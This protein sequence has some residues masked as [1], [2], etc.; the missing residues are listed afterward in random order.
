MSALAAL[1]IVLAMLALSGAFRR[2]LL[3]TRDQQRAEL[4]DLGL[5]L[6]PDGEWTGT[7]DGTLLRHGLPRGASPPQAH[8][9]Q[10]SVLTGG[11]ILYS[12]RVLGTEAP[13]STG[14]P[15]FDA[16]YLSRGTPAERSLLTSAVRRALLGLSQARLSDGELECEASPTPDSLRAVLRVVRALQEL[17]PDPADRLRQMAGSPHAGVRLQG[18]R[19]AA[20]LDPALALELG[21]AERRRKEGLALLGEIDPALQSAGVALLRSLGPEADQ[22]MIEVLPKLDGELL[23]QIARALGEVGSV[24]AVAPLRSRQA[25]L[26]VLQ[27]GLSQ[28]LDRAVLSIQARARG[29]RGGL[30]VAGPVQE[31]GALSVA[32]TAGALSQRERSGG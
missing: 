18:L 5:D 4:S 28:T 32:G 13:Q 2:V 19:L 27:G 10:V 15:S 20:E 11:L 24:A 16:R 8:A 12:H 31:E 29:E 14:D 25:R 17:P 30:A 3:K 6:G 22:A 23:E 7:I 26:S 9:W 1:W 21:P